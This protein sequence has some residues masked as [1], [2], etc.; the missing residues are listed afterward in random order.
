MRGLLLSVPGQGEA[1][2]DDPHGTGIVALLVVIAVCL[3]IFF[4]KV[5]EPSGV[6]MTFLF[7][8]M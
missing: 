6:F 8:Q 3:T 2:M 4:L 1:D 5:G 7:P